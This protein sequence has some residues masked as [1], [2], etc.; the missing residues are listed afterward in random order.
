MLSEPLQRLRSS[1]MLETD[2]LESL[3]LGLVLV[4]VVGCSYYSGP[5]SPNTGRAAQAAV[6]RR[7]A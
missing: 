5:P 1:V 6:P 7:S 2:R 4:L 3:A